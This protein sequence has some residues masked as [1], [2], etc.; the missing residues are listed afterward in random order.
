MSKNRS[1][2]EGAG[3]KPE[4]PL[5]LGLEQV[6]ADLVLA[7]AV[8]LQRSLVAERLERVRREPADAQIGRSLREPGERRHVDRLELSDLVAPDRGDPRQVVVV[9]PAL[10]ADRGELAAR[11]VLARP[12][13]GL[14]PLL[15]V[16]R[17]RRCAVRR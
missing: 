13:I 5:L 15:D 6:D 11:A 2:R 10:P 16:P 1:P 8:E 7:V 3:S 14:G 4:P 17:S 9:H 12:R